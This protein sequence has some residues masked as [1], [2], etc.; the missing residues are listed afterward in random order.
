MEN[1]IDKNHLI[2]KRQD[3]ILKCQL[4]KKTYNKSRASEN[5]F[6]LQN[7][8][9]WK[10]EVTFLKKKKYKISFNEKWKKEIIYIR[11]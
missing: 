7:Q 10:C 8:N 9:V 5:R 11:R 4:P 6:D 1:S 2:F 3:L